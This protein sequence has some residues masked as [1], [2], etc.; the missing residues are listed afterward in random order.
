MQSLEQFQQNADTATTTTADD[1]FAVD[2][3][4]SSSNMHTTVLSEDCILDGT[5]SKT[6]TLP[7]RDYFDGLSNPR[8]RSLND[9]ADSGFYSMTRKPRGLVKKTKT[10]TKS[11]NST[12]I[13]VLPLSDFL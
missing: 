11:V 5:P 3:I 4:E 7:S 13:N 8:W 2:V 10:K 9:A 1:R 6:S 12:R